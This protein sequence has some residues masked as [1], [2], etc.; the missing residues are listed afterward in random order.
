MAGIYKVI[1]VEPNLGASGV[2]FDHGDFRTYAAA[3]SVARI[4]KKAFPGRTSLVL[5]PPAK[6]PLELEW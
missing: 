3:A 4:V 6:V 2:K 1:S 5:L